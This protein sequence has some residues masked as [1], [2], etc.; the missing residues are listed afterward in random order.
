MKTLKYFF[1]LAL[2]TLV[3]GANAQSKS[4]LH[5]SIGMPMGDT[6]DFISKTS[7]RGVLFEYEK[8][9]QPNI[10]V[11]FQFGWNTFYEDKPRGT[12]PL[13]NGAITSNQYRYLNSIPLHITGKYYFTG[14]DS[15][16]RPFIGLGAGTNYME[17]RNDNGLYS[18]V[19]KGWV[20]ALAPKAGVLFPFSY[21]ASLSV[22]LDYNMT[23][24]SSKVPQQNWLGIN[25]GF[26]WDY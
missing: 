10:G 7:W 1:T 23:F 3:L 25:V 6:K 8:L 5:Y 20:M 2:I 11:G 4:N 22:S 19:D 15:N 18:T 12:Y 9:I 17:Q 14:D 13:E 16:V 21:S 24:E 26:S